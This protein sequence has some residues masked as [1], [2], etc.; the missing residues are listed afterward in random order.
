ML[1]CQAVN[2]S[3]KPRKILFDFIYSTPDEE[4]A[5]SQIAVSLSSN[6]YDSQFEVSLAKSPT[7]N[8]FKDNPNAETLYGASDIIIL[9]AISKDKKSFNFTKSH[10]LFKSLNFTENKYL[11]CIILNS[12]LDSYPNL[13]IS[14]IPSDYDYFRSIINK[15][16]NPAAKLV[17]LEFS[18]ADQTNIGASISE[19]LKQ[20]AK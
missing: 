10:Y 18:I 17:Y 19:A 13:E 15:E 2:I 11:G 6:T 5:L 7:K 16:V 20:Y 14:N 9:L 8:M 12:I 4:S 1:N 3:N